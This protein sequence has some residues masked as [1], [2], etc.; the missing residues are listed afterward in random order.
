MEKLKNI[1]DCI[2]PRCLKDASKGKSIP[3]YHNKLDFKCP[4][5]GYVSYEEAFDPNEI[6]HPLYQKN[7]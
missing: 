1:N 3:G 5:C 2:C 7:S 6:G 4:H